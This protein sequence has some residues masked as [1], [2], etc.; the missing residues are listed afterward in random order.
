VP[1]GDLHVYDQRK[2]LG[3]L[4]PAPTSSAGHRAVP[5]DQRDRSRQ[6]TYMTRLMSRFTWTTSK[7]HTPGVAV[8]ARAASPVSRIAPPRTAAVHALVGRELLR[9]CT[10]LWPP[11]LFVGYWLHPNRAVQGSGCSIQHTR[12]LSAKAARLSQTALNRGSRRTTAVVGSIQA[13]NRASESDASGGRVAVEDSTSA[14]GH[15]Q[16][17]LVLLDYGAVK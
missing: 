13:N 14:G 9:S 7:V 12:A 11:T 17:R 16:V 6:G 1:N 2:R 15:G 8:C 5:R 3:R 10:A 4:L